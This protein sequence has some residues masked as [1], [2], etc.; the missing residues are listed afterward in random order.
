MEI[1]VGQRFTRR[2]SAICLFVVGLVPA[3]LE[4]CQADESTEESKAVVQLLDEAG[5]VSQPAP[6]RTKAAVVDCD[7][8]TAELALTADL[9][10]LSGA[11]VVGALIITHSSTQTKI[12]KKLFPREISVEALLLAE[13]GKKEQGPFSGTIRYFSEWDEYNGTL[14]LDRNS[15]L[16]DSQREIINI[17]GLKIDRRNCPLP[18]T[19]LI[20]SP[21]G[22]RI[23]ER[24]KSKRPAGKNGG[25]GA[26]LAMNVPELSAS[27]DDRHQSDDNGCWMV[28]PRPFFKRKPGPGCPTG[29]V[30]QDQCERKAIDF[31]ACAR[32]AGPACSKS[33][34]RNGRDCK[35]E[36]LECS[37]KSSSPRGRGRTTG[38]QL[39][40]CEEPR[41]PVPDS[42]RSFCP[43]SWPGEGNATPGD[44]PALPQECLG[45]FGLDMRSCK[46]W[47]TRATILSPP[48]FKDVRGLEDCKDSLQ[49]LSKCLTALR[50]DDLCSSY[51]G[52]PKGDKIRD[53][54]SAIEECDAC[55]KSKEQD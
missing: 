22:S 27:G 39:G 20:V 46:G 11:R 53:V 29:Q 9:V 23:V 36:F 38:K 17:S 55:V 19:R 37:W 50:A 44:C 4:T 18:P 10:S 14:V 42:I 35:E 8:Q 6:I 2:L 15:N 32:C 30:T 33:W 16:N 34:V 40:T 54:T 3:V 52:K 49:K 45:E 47:E 48:D 26:V 13:E 12:I 21:D 51:A 24:K 43:F 5:E 28:G 31:V 1:S 7:K 41:P 25:I